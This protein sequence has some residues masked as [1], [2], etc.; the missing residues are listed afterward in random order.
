MASVADTANAYIQNGI[1]RVYITPNECA[2]AQLQPATKSISGM[3]IRVIC[4]IGFQVTTLPRIDFRC[5][6]FNE[7]AEEL[8]DPIQ[9]WTGMRRKQHNKAGATFRSAAA[10]LPVTARP[11]HNRPR[12]RRRGALGCALPSRGAGLWRCN[13]K[14]NG[15]GPRPG[16]RAVRTGQRISFACRV[17]SSFQG[18]ATRRS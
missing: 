17:V 15:P 10:S 14:T 13:S 16:P 4:A 9:P 7:G 8:T 2:C 1:G 3:T 6:E 11:A 5:S 12:G 18:T